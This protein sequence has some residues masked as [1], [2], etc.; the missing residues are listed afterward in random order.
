MRQPLS[1]NNLNQPHARTLLLAVAAL[2]LFTLSACSAFRFTPVSGADADIACRGTDSVYHDACTYL[3]REGQLTLVAGPE[4]L[5]V[6]P[7]DVA[8]SNAATI[9]QSRQSW[10]ARR[11][12]RAEITVD[13]T[14]AATA[15]RAGVPAAM[16]LDGQSYFALYYLT[17]PR[18]Y[19][20]PGGSVVELK[21]IP[22]S[23]RSIALNQQPRGSWPVTFGA[24]QSGSFA[25]P[26][27]PDAPPATL[28]RRAF[29]ADAASVQSQLTE[30]SDAESI[31][32]AQRA[33]RQLAPSAAIPGVQWQMVVFR[34]EAAAAF[35]VP[36]G[37]LFVSEDLVRDSSD[38]ELAAVTAHLMGHVRY[39]HYR[40]EPPAVSADSLPVPSAKD[41]AIKMAE[42]EAVETLKIGLA[43]LAATPEAIV[44]MG[45]FGLG[46]AP[47]LAM[48]TAF[49]FAPVAMIAHSQDI[50][51]GDFNAAMEK[52]LKPGEGLSDPAPPVKPFVDVRAN[53][54][55]ANYA[56]ARYLRWAGIP[57]ESLFYAMRRVKMSGSQSLAAPKDSR[58][59]FEA[60]QNHGDNG[61]IDLGRM[62]DAGE[63][64]NQRP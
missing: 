49:V 3:F 22:T 35:A 44:A 1:S 25:V 61:A 40:V 21:D 4:I 53:E 43:G 37:T 19:F 48:S 32:R 52:T 36:N 31:A 5:A 59:D 2:W 20:F 24:E 64:T 9:S 26:Q 29:A 56:A 7:G 8:G 45:V 55:E 10:K 39:G 58:T 6:P 47:G 18:S 14:V 51:R 46:A 23:I 54:R 41:C 34:G 30:A 38:I 50:C 15:A 13:K 62:L 17:P 60:M 28:N 42:F 57:P 63:I 33:L 16:E 12:L 11:I 27:T